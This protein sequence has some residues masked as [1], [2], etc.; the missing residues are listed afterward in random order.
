MSELFLA[1]PQVNASDQTKKWKNNG[2]NL[3]TNQ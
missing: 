3:G 1:N 2:K